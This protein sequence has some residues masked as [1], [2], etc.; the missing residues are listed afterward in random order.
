M[1]KG[2]STKT[3]PNKGKGARPVTGSTSAGKYGPGGNGTPKKKG[4]R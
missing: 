3:T 2:T 4:Y 1:K